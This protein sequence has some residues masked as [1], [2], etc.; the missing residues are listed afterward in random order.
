MEAWNMSEYTQ[1]LV[2][3]HCMI[4]SKSL[5]YS[6]HLLIIDLQLAVGFCS[7]ELSRDANRDQQH[8]ALLT[9]RRLVEVSFA[10]RICFL[11]TMSTLCL[12]PGRRDS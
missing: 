1:E 12:R 4:A 10:A 9:I 11:D 6:S 2:L 7:M 3:K 8:Q 5:G